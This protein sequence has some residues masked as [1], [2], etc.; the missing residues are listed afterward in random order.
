MCDG[1]K[2]SQHIGEAGAIDIRRVLYG[3]RRGGFPGRRHGLRDGYRR[4]PGVT[5]PR[6][7]WRSE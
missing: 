1:S 4:D 7:T 5:M 2:L 6:T 3:E